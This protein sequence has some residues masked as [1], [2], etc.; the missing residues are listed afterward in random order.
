MTGVTGS[1]T[2]WTLTTASQAASTAYTVFVST[3][4]RASDGSALTVNSRAYTSF[5]A[6]NVTGAVALSATACKHAGTNGE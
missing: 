3:V 2:T 6:F 4:T 1:G 5:P